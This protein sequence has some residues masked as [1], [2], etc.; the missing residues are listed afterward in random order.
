MNKYVITGGP[1]AGKTSVITYLQNQ[2]IAI[3]PEAARMV[4]EE[5]EIMQGDL[6]PWKNRTGFQRAIFQRQKDLEA[7][8][9]GQ[10]TFLDRGFGDN[11]AYYT[12]D[13]TDIPSD[14][15]D[16]AKNA[17]Y[18]AIFLLD[19]LPKYV[20]DRA[21]KEDEQTAQKIHQAIATAYERLGYTVIRVPVMPIEKRGDYI[22][23]KS[24]E[25]C[26]EVTK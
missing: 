3:L 21:R 5:Q 10:P 1:G 14:E 2:G 22:L 4:I 9:N 24:I 26:Q 15:M 20:N 12:L 17:N 25:I 7:R 23:E 13:G 18:E 16:A 19:P 11:I 8:I 6:V